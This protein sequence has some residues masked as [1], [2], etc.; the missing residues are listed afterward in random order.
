MFQYIY[1][2]NIYV[3]IHIYVMQM[4]MYIDIYMTKIYL[5]YRKCVHMHIET[6]VVMY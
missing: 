5:H 3:F 6:Y 2:H 1:M 4:H